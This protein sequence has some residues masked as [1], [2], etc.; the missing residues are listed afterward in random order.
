V[1][2]QKQNCFTTM[3][4]LKERMLLLLELK[5]PFGQNG[6]QGLDG[7]P[8]QKRKSMFMKLMDDNAMKK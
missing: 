5:T 3:N 2:V 7:E 4:Y 8:H 6:V 1:E